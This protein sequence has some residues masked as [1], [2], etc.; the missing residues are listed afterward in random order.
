M[1]KFGQLVYR[2]QFLTIRHFCVGISD[3]ISFN[4]QIFG[5]IQTFKP[6]FKPLK[7]LKIDKS[8]DVSKK[9]TVSKRPKSKR[10]F[11]E[12]DDKYLVKLVQKHGY[13]METFKIGAKEMG[14]KYPSS[15]KHRFDEY[16]EKQ[17]KVS[18]AFSPEEDKTI[19]DHITLH[20]KTRKSYADIAKKLDR[21][22]R[23]IN[24]R[25]TLLLSTNEFETNSIR[26]NWK[27]LD[28][29]KLIDFIIKLKQI[30][31][32]DVSSLEDVKPSDL[33]D[34]ASEMKRSSESCYGRWMRSIVPTIKTHLKNLPMTSE[35]KK[36]ILHHI[37][38]NKIKDK[39]E[40]EIDVLHDIA[41]G[42]TS[43]SLIHYLDILKRETIDGNLKYSEKSLF[44]C[45][46]KRLSEQSRKDPC[47]NENHKNEL[48]RL[49]R[50][51]EIVAY[52]E[53]VFHL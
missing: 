36:D 5:A 40:I 10:Y 43:L 39:R 17:Y 23:S 8:T 49:E 27:L 22:L 12:E 28:D 18:G 35:W 46:S 52:Y 34:F 9:S 48:K 16:I 24:D 26:R 53:S 20:G 4:P 13:S 11:S 7:V 6:Y 41:P 1:I 25:S 37:V 32:K 33:T 44:E 47:F 45:A 3:Q 38:K 42:Q 14:R 31:A 21:S 15:L 51:E 2:S 19:L 29:E 50:C 30:N